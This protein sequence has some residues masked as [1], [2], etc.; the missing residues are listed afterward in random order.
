MNLKLVVSGLFIGLSLTYFTA[1][2]CNFNPY[3]QGELLY[4][5]HC[6]S[7]HMEDG[8][9][10]RDLI[11]TLHQSPFLTGEQI[12]STACLIRFGIKKPDP[13]D[14][15]VETYPMP[16]LHH[17]TETE[18]TNILNYIGNHFGNQSGYVNPIKLQENLDHCP[19]AVPRKY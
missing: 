11:P 7:C 15:E 1:V 14:P 17:L 2:S 18:I 19:N 9:G 5:I 16:P 8:S 12:H 3:S 6:A 10:L 4:R 13:L